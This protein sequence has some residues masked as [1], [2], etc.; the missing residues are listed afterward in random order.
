MKRISG[1]TRTCVPATRGAS[2]G[3]PPP[4]PPTGAGDAFHGGYIAAL[5]EGLD[6]PERL[7]F[8]AATAALKAAVEPPTSKRRRFD[9]SQK[10]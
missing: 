7:S 9:W 2:A 4:P 5:L 10:T 3:R 6:L 1:G 8:A